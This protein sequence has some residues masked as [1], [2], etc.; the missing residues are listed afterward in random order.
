MC[1]AIH[2]KNGMFFGRTLDLEYSYNEM[3]IIAPRNFDFGFP[4]K[5]AIIGM[6][7]VANGYPLFFDGMNEKGLCMAAL[8]FKN[9]AYYPPAKTDVENIGSY[10]VMPFVLSR[11]KTAAEAIKLIED[12]N[13][14][15]KAFSE[16][17]PPSPLHFILADRTDCYTIELCRDG[18]HIYKNE[19]RVLANEPPFPDMMEKLKSF[20]FLTPFEP[21]TPTDSRGTGA[22]GLPGDFSS[23]SRFVR[24]EFINRCMEIVDISQFFKALGT[25]EVP[26]GAIRLE[27]GD[28][29]ITR[30]TSAMDLLQGIYYYKPYEN[31]RITAI[32]IKSENLSGDFLV[33]YPLKREND[34][35]YQN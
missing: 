30:Y 9:S 35:L 12:I 24:A 15:D 7:T 3:V 11:A 25:L 14:C 17:F 28:E 27:N 10:E 32:D 29:V 31:S 13:I 20:S 19:A 21:K 1:T 18:K 16:E 26:R 5:Y 34:I 22:L 2:S 6:G 4:S 33:R 8:R 23:R